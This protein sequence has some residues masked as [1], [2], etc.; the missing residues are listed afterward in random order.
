MTGAAG[1]QQVLSSVML[2]KK[3]QEVD[4]TTSFKVVKV[5]LDEGFWVLRDPGSDN[6]WPAPEEKAAA[7]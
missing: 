5:V 2:D 1:Q 6:I 4:A 3:E 7:K